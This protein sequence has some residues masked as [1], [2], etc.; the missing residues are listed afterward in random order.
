VFARIARFEGADGET[1]ERT[2]DRIRQEAEAAGGPPPGVPAT[3]LLVL[4]D[5]AGG[6]SLVISI[7]ENEA[8]YEEGDRTLG[9]MSPPDDGMGRRV[10]V[11]RYEVAIDV[12]T[13]S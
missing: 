9:E 13:E 7:F 6:K 2:T 11:D 8:D 12:G 10:A 3:R 1:L 4:N 5:T